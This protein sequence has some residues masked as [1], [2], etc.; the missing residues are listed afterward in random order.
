MVPTMDRCVPVLGFY[1]VFVDLIF[2]QWKHLVT[3]M[4]KKKPNNG[5]FSGW[6]MAE[7]RQLTQPPRELSARR[8]LDQSL[9]FV[10]WA[11]RSSAT[12]MSQAPHHSGQLILS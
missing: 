5:L 11:L 2:H 6:G 12:E 7:G 4:Q 1:H 9:V 10:D 3:E 8:T